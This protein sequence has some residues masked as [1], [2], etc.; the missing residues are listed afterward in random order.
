[1]SF[2]QSQERG[3]P[4]ASEGG[5]KATKKKRGTP[6]GD[7]TKEQQGTIYSKGRS[8]TDPQLGSKPRRCATPTHP[9][10][11]KGSAGSTNSSE[12]EEGTKQSKREQTKVQTTQRRP[13]QRFRPFI[14]RSRRQKD[15]RRAPRAV[16]N[17]TN[18]GA[19][20]QGGLWSWYHEQPSLNSLGHPQPGLLNRAERRTNTELH[21]EKEEMVD[22]DKGAG[23][24]IQ[25]FRDIPC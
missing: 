20:D 18:L 25:R 21:V 5:T 11:I 22:Q 8:K 9:R 23:F 12:V 10:R 14:L 24:I 6:R 4:T 15:S 13:D 2:A 3:Q 7:G 16:T 1:M 17:V 19:K